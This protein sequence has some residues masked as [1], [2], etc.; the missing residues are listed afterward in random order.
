MSA[1]DQD[2][3]DEIEKAVHRTEWRIVWLG[4]RAISLVIGIGAVF[5]L[6]KTSTE[7]SGLENWLAHGLIIA[8]AF[9]VDWS[10]GRDFLKAAK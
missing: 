8:V 1:I 3:L 7:L 5:L 2:R 9:A 4:R 10:A 6:H